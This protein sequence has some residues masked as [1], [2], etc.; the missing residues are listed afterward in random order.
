VP[1]VPFQ[2]TVSGTPLATKPQVAAST[3]IPR[4]VAVASENFGQA[5]GQL[6]QD[7]TAGPVSN[8]AMSV[9]TLQAGNVVPAQSVFVAGWALDR[10]AP[11]GSGIDT[12]HVWAQPVGGGSASFLGVATYGIPR[13]DVAAAYGDAR[14][15]NSGYGLLGSINTPGTYDVTVYARS[16]VTQAFTVVQTVRVSVSMPLMYIDTPTQGATVSGSAIAVGG[17]AADL[18]SPDSAGVDAVHVWAYPAAGGAPQFF[19]VAWTGG[20]R[21]DVG[22]ALGAPRFALSG[23]NAFG[24]LPQGDWDLVVYAHSSFA[25]A[26]NNVKVV[27]VHV[28]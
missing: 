2:V 5:M 23:F 15:T 13:P 8:P 28:Q 6:L 7:G 4:F 3:T 17:W 20:V 24:T 9:D 12:V 27:R 21:P 18:A 22:A 11:Q 16:T 25:N 1:G 10:G 14:F 26:F 19:A